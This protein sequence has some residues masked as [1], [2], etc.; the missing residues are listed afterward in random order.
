MTRL[1]QAVGEEHQAGTGRQLDGRLDELRGVADAQGQPGVDLEVTRIVVRGHQQRRRMAG[2]GQHDPGALVVRPVPGG[3]GVS[4]AGDRRRGARR[5]VDA[6]QAGRERQARQRGDHHVEPG[7]QVGGPPLLQRVGAQR[8]AQLA[9]HRGG[10]QPPPHHVADREPDPAVGQRDDV[11]EVA[12][13]LRAGGAR[14]VL[15]RHVGALEH[16]RVRRQQRALQRPAGLLG[17]AVHPGVDERER[18]PARE[19]LRECLLDLRVRRVAVCPT[20][21]QGP[22]DLVAVRHRHGHRRPPAELTEARVL[23]GVGEQRAAQ[24]R[25][26]VLDAHRLAGA[27][28]QARGVVVSHAGRVGGGERPDVGGGLWVGM[29]DQDQVE[30]VALRRTQPEHGAVAEARARQ[31]DHHLDD[32]IW[33]E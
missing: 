22:D 3:V 15:H 4:R 30:H 13:D 20:Q 9:H 7:Q 5:L 6:V 1:D 29:V 19:I 25:G 12:T 27:H 26:E 16:G 18:G 28:H 33:L 24:R 14:P 11:V 8:G 31:L 10:A 17:L 32:P 21:S 2:A 23:P